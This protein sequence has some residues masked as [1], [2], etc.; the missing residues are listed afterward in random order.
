[1]RNGE[2]E[3]ELELLKMGTWTMR[4]LVTDRIE[5]VE[6]IL[7]LDLYVEEGQLKGTV[8][9]RSL[10]PLRQVWLV[11]TGGVVDLGEL[12]SG[13]TASVDTTVATFARVLPSWECANSG[14][15]GH[16]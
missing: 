8:T 5:R 13:G 6:E 16:L 14:V 11:S 2:E 10:M 3:S 4:S 1:M 9:N 7:S 15:L 12:E